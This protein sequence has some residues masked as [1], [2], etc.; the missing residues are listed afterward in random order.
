MNSVVL[1]LKNVIKNYRQGKQNLEVL[2]GVNLE[3]KE[4]EIVALV[5]QSGAGKSTLLRLLSGVYFANEG[6]IEYDG[7][8]PEIETTREDIFLLP[9][10]PYFTNTSNIK[11]MLDT[12]K[13]FYP[14][15]C[16][17]T[18]K[19]LLSEFKLDEKKPLRTFSKDIS[20]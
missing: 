19:R 14:S 6:A 15:L 7:K 18:Y 13:H 3:I 12:Y 5:G 10:D 1:E 16:M 2:S 17:E 8:S 4:Q 20:A 11:S 9:D